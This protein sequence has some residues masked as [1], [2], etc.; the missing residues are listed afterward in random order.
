MRKQATKAWYRTWDIE[1]LNKWVIINIIII[2]PN[3]LLGLG[4]LALCEGHQ[5][6]QGDVKH[7]V[8]LKWYSVKSGAADCCPPR[9]S[10][11]T[12]PVWCGLSIT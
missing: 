10:V 5:T 7:Y 3:S 2:D 9:R 8:H 4:F 1:I 6:R 12:T 11:V